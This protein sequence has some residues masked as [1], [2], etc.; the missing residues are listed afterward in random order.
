MLKQSLKTQE[1]LK[2]LKILY[3]NAI[4]TCILDIAKFAD[5]LWKIADASRTHGMCHVIHV[6][7]GSFSGKI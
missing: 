6:F 2:E 1:K 5:F 7:F 3:Q 4:Y